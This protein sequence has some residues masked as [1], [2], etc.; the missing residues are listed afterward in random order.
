MRKVI[1]KS[2]LCSLLCSFVFLAVPSCIFAQAAASTSAAPAAIAPVPNPCPRFAPGSVIHQPA[3]L[4]S[5]NGVL[6]VQFSY[7]TR[8]DSVGRSLFCFM[9]P[10]GLQNPTLHVR[11]GDHLIITVTNNTTNAPLMMTLNAPNCGPG[12][13]KMTFSSL[14]IHYHG[15][16]TSPTCHSDEVIKTVINFGQTFQYNVAIPADEPPGLY[17]YH[18]HVH[19]IAE[20]ALLGGA[21]GALVVD[22]IEDVQPAVSRLR[23]RILLVRDQVTTQSLTQN[24]GEGSG[25]DP[26]GAPF[27]EITINNITTNTTTDITKDPP[28]TT[29]TPLSFT[30]SRAKNS[31]GGFPT[32]LLIPFSICNMSSTAFRKPCTSLPSTV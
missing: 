23:H 11:P 1:C 10:S 30:W 3:A 28:V 18:P 31:S 5:R 19:G 17:W 13:N 12:G 2:C 15:T 14:N 20:A 9:T 6:S 8:P 16:N 7:Q 32:R 26:N 22:G 24:V 4:F 21:S 25:N 29:Y 27:Q